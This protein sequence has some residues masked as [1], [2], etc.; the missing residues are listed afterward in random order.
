MFRKYLTVLSFLVLVPAAS[1][2]EDEFAVINSGTEIEAELAS[3]L[4]SELNVKSTLQAVNNNPENLLLQVTLRANEEKGIPAVKVIIDTF[5]Y[6]RDKE[7]AP[8]SQ[9]IKIDS[10]P[11]IEWAIGVESGAILEWLNTWNTKLAL[12]MRLYLASGRLVASN[13]L[14]IY[15]GLPL[16]KK[17][18]LAAFHEA[19]TVW[20]PIIADLKAKGLI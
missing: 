10:I 2:A 6:R 19:Y 4:Q 16:K 5:V 18:V 1:A 17:R 7:Q 14:L 3:L 12:P 9:A 20:Q 8:L 13:N 11:N 15:K